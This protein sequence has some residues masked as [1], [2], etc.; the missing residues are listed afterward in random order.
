MSGERRRDLLYGVMFTSPWIIGFTVFMAVPLVLSFYFSFCDYSILN[1]P[2][3]V[4]AQNYQDMMQDEVFWKT[5]RNTFYF[6]ALSLPL[7]TVL[8]LGLALLLNTDLFGR[9]FFRTL[10]F[11]PSLVPLVAL[12]ILWREMLHVEYG[13]VNT[14]MRSIGF[15]TIDWLGDPRHAMHGLVFSSLWGV[16]NATVLYLASL[17]DVPR[18]LYEA[19]EVDGANAW[20]RMVH[21]T[22]P[23]IS[24]VIYFNLLMGCIGS[25]Q[26]F[27]LPY[28]MTKGEPARSTMFYAMY[29]FDQA[30]SYLNMGYA[31][32]MAWVL[33][34]LIAGLSFLAHL[35][36]KRYVHQGDGS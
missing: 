2:V 27:A 28:V 32:A 7:G 19:A 35:L 24:P 13:I 20:Q 9:A 10:F 5:L 3:Y 16:G 21:V 34:I 4:G 23:M 15:E 36:S 31:S 8:A 29:L 17:Q 25:L 18:G 6:A 26:V 33:F 11:L 30:F 1:A 14:L 12:A 22:L